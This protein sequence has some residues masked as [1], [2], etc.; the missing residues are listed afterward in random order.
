MR[1]D[2]VTVVDGSAGHSTSATITY[3]KNGKP[4]TKDVIALADECLGWWKK[5]L[6]KHGLEAVP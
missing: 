6:K 2:E 1:I 4:Q 3:E 5:Y